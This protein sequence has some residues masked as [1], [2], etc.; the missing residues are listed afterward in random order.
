MKHI[1]ALLLTC[2][3]LAALMLPIL[4]ATPQN[5]AVAAVQE[6]VGASLGAD[7][8]G[9]AVVLFE[10]GQRV[11]LE[12]FGY[13]DIGERTLL[14][15]DTAFELGALSRLFVL[16]ACER[17]ATEGRLDLNADVTTYLPADFVEKL[18]LSYTTTV[19]DLLYGMASFEG[20]SFDLRFDKPSY[21]FDTLREALLSE[22]PAQLAVPGSFYSDSAFGIGLAAFAVECITGVPYA[23]YVTQSILVPLGMTQT[24]LDPR[25]D[26]P[27]QAPAKGHIV[28]GEGSF[29]VAARDGRSYAGIWPADGAISTAADLSLLMAHLLHDEGMRTLLST[30]RK[31]GVFDIS[32]L[33][34]SVTNGAASTTGKT[35]HF[36]ATL[37]LDARNGKAVLVLTNTADSALHALPSMLCGIV[38]GINV[39]ADGMP[40]LS[41]YEGVYAPA[42]LERDSLV[43]RLA[44]KD[45]AVR[46]KANEDGTLQCGEQRLRQIARGVFADADA[47][48]QVAVLQFLLT[49]EGEIIAM[50]DA[51]GESYLPVAFLQQSAPAAVLYVLLLLCVLYFLAGGIW[52]VFSAVSAY[53]RGE[54]GMPRR[55]LLTWV[56]SALLALLALLQVLVGT[57]LGASAMASFFTALS[58]L[59]LFAAIAATVSYLFAF[60]TAF[61]ERGRGGRVVRNALVFLGLLFLCG[62]WNLILI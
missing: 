14:T 33:G 51:R 35:T 61:G 56:C 17:L 22:V 10:N 21:C 58:V 54:R 6:A 57:A 42:T 25:A 62:Y 60:F 5:A 38:P 52:V 15:A 31:N 49:V 23:E 59:S 43:G 18:K 44:I 41:N 30:C 37:A 48:G 53:L 47:E 2:C 13:A 45:R 32:P 55:F 1:V 4:A 29:A 36:A 8:P 27:I 28:T 24:L 3:L 39:E 19:S 11:M 12:G 34:A 40:D 20:R 46:V 16:M 9:A 7:T 50:T 26:S